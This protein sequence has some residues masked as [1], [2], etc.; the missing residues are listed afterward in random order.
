MKYYK[1]IKY[2]RVSFYYIHALINDKSIRIGKDFGSM[3]R[4]KPLYFVEIDGEIIQH[5]FSSQKEAKIFVLNEQA[6]LFS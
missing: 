1:K 2:N 3:Q 6:I 4:S 5:G